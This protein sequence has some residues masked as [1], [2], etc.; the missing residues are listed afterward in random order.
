MPRAGE[1]LEDWAIIPIHHET[2]PIELSTFTLTIQKETEYIPKRAQ[3][4]Y[5]IMKFIHDNNNNINEDMYN[6]WNTT[7]KKWNVILQWL[8]CKTNETNNKWRAKIQTQ[9]GPIC[10]QHMDNTIS[11]TK[12]WQEIITSIISIPTR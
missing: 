2:P 11:L 4:L 8:G 7:T 3:E 9:I 10:S 1:N 12:M 6:N 5:K